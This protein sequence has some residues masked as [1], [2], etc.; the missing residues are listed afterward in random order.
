MKTAILLAAA[1]LLVGSAAAAPVLT[2]DYDSE[3][4]GVDPAVDGH[5]SVDAVVND[6]GTASVSVD[7]EP[8]V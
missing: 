7:G 2:I 3:V 4:Y 6:D 5:H 8:V 1:L